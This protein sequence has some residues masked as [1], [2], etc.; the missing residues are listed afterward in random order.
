GV[1]PGRGGGGRAAGTGPPGH[2]R[3]DMAAGTWPPGHGRRDMAAG[4]WPPGHGT[5]QPVATDCP[6]SSMG[7]GGDAAI[8]W[9][10]HT[11]RKKSLLGSPPFLLS[12]ST[13]CR[14]RVVRQG[15][16]TGSAAYPRRPPPTSSRSATGS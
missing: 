13:V 5:G 1:A 16:S 2:G 10:P 6:A 9:P 7:E 8:A 15:L 11:F 4:T 14:V 12:D 3:R